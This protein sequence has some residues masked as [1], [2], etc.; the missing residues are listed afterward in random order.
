MD[1][2]MCLTTVATRLGD[3]CGLVAFDR[4]GAGGRAARAGPRPAR[5]G[6]RGD[7]R[8]RA[9][10]AESDYRGAF[11]AGA[12]PLPPP[13]AARAV[14]RPGRAGGRRVAA[15][16]PCRCSSATTSCVVAAVRDPD[17]VGWADRAARRR[18]ARPTARRPPR[19]P[20]A[21]RDRAV[22][23]LRG[24]G[25]I[26][27]DAPP[28]QLAAA[29]ADAYLELKATRPAL[30]RSGQARAVRSPAVRRRGRARRRRRCSRVGRGAAAQDDDVEPERDATTSTPMPTRDAGG[31]AAG[32]DEALDRA[33]HDERERP[34][35]GR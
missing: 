26:V 8:P 18:R 21:E 12:G 31:Q 19:A 29:L 35:R 32:R 16:R 13:V 5:P 11:T 27:V 28:G 25:A 9:G 7:V 22:A 34:G 10:L 30:G 20:L 3:R 2:V 15:A 4:D 14:H 24:L 33:G 6:G 1:A 23:R 17:V